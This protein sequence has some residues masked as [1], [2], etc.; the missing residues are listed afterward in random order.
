MILI[1]STVLKSKFYTKDFFKFSFFNVINYISY[2]FLKLIAFF[3]IYYLGMANILF[4]I[5]FSINIISLNRIL[6]KLLC[7]YACKTANSILVSY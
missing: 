5:K 3:K 4:I 7:Y 6:K 1:L 2:K